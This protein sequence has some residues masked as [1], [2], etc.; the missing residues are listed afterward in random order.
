MAPG[1]AHG[2]HGDPSAPARLRSCV[3]RLRTTLAAGDEEAA[4]AV[5]LA[6]ERTARGWRDDL[7]P[8]TRSQ[9][10]ALLLVFDLLREGRLDEALGL[11]DGELLRSFPGEAR[12]DDVAPA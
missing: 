2:N 10:R 9:V 4:R 7:N 5:I 6:D 8:R 11:V 3:D 12:L 1:H